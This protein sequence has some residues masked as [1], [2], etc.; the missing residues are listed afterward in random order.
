MATREGV[1]NGRIE[2]KAPEAQEE[3]EEVAIDRLPPLGENATRQIPW[4]RLWDL[5]RPSRPALAVMLALGLAGSAAGV[6]PALMLAPL[7]DGLTHVTHTGLGAAAAFAVLC[8]ALVVEA[9][10]FVGAD[11]LYG[12]VTGRLSRDLRVLMLRGVAGPTPVGEGLASRFVS[13]AEAPAELTVGTLDVAVGGVFG[14]GAALSALAALD[15]RCAVIVGCAAPAVVVAS[16][17]LQR[18][19]GELAGDRQAALEAMTGAL[20]AAL[21]RRPGAFHAAVDRIFAVETRL[22]RFESQSTHVPGVITGAGS[23]AV[24]MAAAASGLHRP[25]ALLAVF[26]LA[27]RGFRATD[28]LL[29]VGLDVELVRASIA[30]CFE[31]IDRRG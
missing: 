20:P 23:F 26:A 9:C 1:T 12:R 29:Y 2:E 14:L 6:V 17:R 4:R 27:E 16:R 7:V 5:L 30:R 3:E 21:H 25:G 31:L 18:H 28:D 8:A 11:A 15:L 13:D 19:T 24:V 22:S 10:C